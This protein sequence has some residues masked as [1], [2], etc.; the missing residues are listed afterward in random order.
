MQT[1]DICVLSPLKAAVWKSAVR[2]RRLQLFI[3]GKMSRKAYNYRKTWRGAESHAVSVYVRFRFLSAF[4]FSEMS[5]QC[6]P[7]KFGNPVF[8]HKSFV[9]E[10]ARTVN[11]PAVGI[12]FRIGKVPERHTGPSFIAPDFVQ[13]RLQ[14]F[15]LILFRPAQSAVVARQCGGSDFAQNDSFAAILFLRGELNDFAQ[16]VKHFLLRKL[17]G[18]LLAVR[19]LQEGPA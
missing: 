12:G 9:I 14:K 7:G 16:G 11:R 4:Q 8:R 1:E 3:C 19:E 13:N 6:F 17:L 2:E 18:I 15:R 5:R 10:A